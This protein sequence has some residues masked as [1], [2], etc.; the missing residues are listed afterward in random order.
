MQVFKSATAPQRFSRT[1]IATGVVL[2]LASP[3]LMAQEEAFAIEEVVVTA[4]K[5]EQSM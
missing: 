3:A 2:A 1:P 4:Q 5:R